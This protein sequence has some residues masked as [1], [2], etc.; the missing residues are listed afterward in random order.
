MIREIWPLLYTAVE[1]LSSEDAGLVGLLV[2]E[3]VVDV[4]FRLPI[5]NP[6]SAR[7]MTRA[8]RF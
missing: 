6:H 1:I 5:L 3:V 8:C 2:V 4:S 7:M